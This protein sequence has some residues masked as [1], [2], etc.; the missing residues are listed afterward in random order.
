MAIVGH[1][2]RRLINLKFSRPE[3][4]ATLVIGIEEVQGAEM[5]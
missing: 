4:R 5:E 2:D 3:D 1:I